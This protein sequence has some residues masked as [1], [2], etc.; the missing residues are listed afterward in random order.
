MI[1]I[2]L[3]AR[4]FA[5]NKERDKARLLCNYILNEFP[6]YADVRTLK[7]RTLAWDKKYPKAETEFLEVIK[8]TPFYSD[9]YLALMDMYWWSEQNE[10]GILIGKKGL[11]NKVDAPE[12]G[13]KLA[14]AY[15]RTNNTIKANK[16]IDSVI[17]KYPK[18][19][20]FIKIKKSFE[21]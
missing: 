6:N 11:N 15:F 7:G 10:K 13:A 5:F 17:H 2:F 20:E 19:P 21:K 4:D 18:N 12:L 3:R 14:Q 16:I 8:R 9:S 1:E